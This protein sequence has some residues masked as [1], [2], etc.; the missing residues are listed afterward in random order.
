MVDISSVCGLHV[1]NLDWL[2]IVESFARLLYNIAAPASICVAKQ[3]AGDLNW[4]APILWV[5]ALD[6]TI[7]VISKCKILIWLPQPPLDNYSPV[8]AKAFSLHTP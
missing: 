1:K 6:N 3:P 4:L 7:T 2:V 5:H 8:P